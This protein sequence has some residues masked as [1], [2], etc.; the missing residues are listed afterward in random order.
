MCPLQVCVRTKDTKYGGI[1]ARPDKDQYV[2]GKMVD[3]G[4]APDATP[5]DATTSNEGKHK[6]GKFVCGCYHNY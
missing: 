6:G 3:G 1:C 2:I 4:A 5:E